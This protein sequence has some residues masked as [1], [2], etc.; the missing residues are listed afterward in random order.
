MKNNVSQTARHFQDRPL[1]ETVPYTPL[2][3]TSF[4]RTDY[5]DPILRVFLALCLLV[6][7]AAVGREISA[8]PSKTVV[9]CLTPPSALVCTT[10]APHTKPAAL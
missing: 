3:L 7:L 6:S 4:D 8:P 2:Y 9:Q 1:P 10:S 5:V